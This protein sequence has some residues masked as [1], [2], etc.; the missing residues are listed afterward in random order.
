MSTPRLIK[1]HQQA[2]LLLFVQCMMHISYISFFALFFSLMSRLVSFINTSFSFNAYYFLYKP[3]HNIST[4]S[5]KKMQ[6]EKRSNGHDIECVCHNCEDIDSGLP[7]E[8]TY[9]EYERMQRLGASMFDS[10]REEE[11]DMGYI[12]IPKDNSVNWFH[13]D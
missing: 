2:I 1:D 6:T 11:E 4:H 12:T 5:G 7:R 13:R 8:P 3:Q 10:D 9:S